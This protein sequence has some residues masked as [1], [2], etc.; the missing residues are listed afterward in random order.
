MSQIYLVKNPETV[1]GLRHLRELRTLST[2][3]DLLASNDVLRVMDI[4]LQRMKAIE[5]FVAQGTWTQATLLELIPAEGEQR[6]FFRT[7]LKAVQQEAKAES[8]T[9]K[10]QWQMKPRRQW[11]PYVPGTGGE[12]KENEGEKGDAPPLNTPKGKKG[13]GKGKKGR[14]W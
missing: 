8:R 2:M 7:E 3:V 6:A 13:K 10:D 14:R 5:V 9:Q 12:K 1:I 11:E 4:A